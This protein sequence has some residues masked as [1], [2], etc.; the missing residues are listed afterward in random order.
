MEENDPDSESPSTGENVPSGSSERR[1]EQ[2]ASEEHVFNLSA[3]ALERGLTPAEFTTLKTTLEEKRFERQRAHYDLDEILEMANNLPSLQSKPSML[4]RKVGR[5]SEILGKLAEGLTELTTEIDRTIRILGPSFDEENPRTNFYD[6]VI[7]EIESALAEQRNW[8][9]STNVALFRTLS[10]NTL[11]ACVQPDGDE[12]SVYESTPTHL[13]NRQQDPIVF[14][15]GFMHNDS[16]VRAAA[17]RDKEDANWMRATESGQPHPQLLPSDA[18]PTTSAHPQLIVNEPHLQQTPFPQI[19]E[20]QGKYAQ[21]DLN[22][23]LP[24]EIN[25][26]SFPFQCIGDGGSRKPHSRIPNLQRNEAVYDSI[27]TLH[28]R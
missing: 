8:L 7:S 27:R 28:I 16:I 6:M 23:K 21:Q 24:S 19:G 1:N 17:I 18:K 14:R 25:Q 3:L 20:F 15:K 22:N 11:P 5:I 10:V 13:Q 9:S 26:R 12:S 4:N 2:S